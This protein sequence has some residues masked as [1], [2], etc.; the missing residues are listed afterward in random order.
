MHRIDTP[1]AQ[2]DK[3]GQ[4]KNGF[5]NGDPS[6]GIRATYLNSDMWD[7]VQEEICTV[8]EKSGIILE[9][10]QH[11]QLYEAIVG[12][13]ADSIPDALLKKNNL[14]DVLDK[15]IAR[16]NLALGTAATSNVQK[17]ATDGT[18]NALMANGAWGIGANGIGMT[19]S[20]ILS[21]TSI[22]NAFF[23]QYGGADNHF[24]SYGAGVHISY[25]TGGGNTLRLTA[26]L[27]VDASGNLSVEWLE[28][29]RNDGAVK[30]KRLQKLYGP[31]NKPTSDTVN[32]ITRDECHIA[33]FVSGNKTNPYM[34]HTASN[35]VIVLLTK[36]EASEKYQPKGSYTPAGE[37]YTKA[38]SDARYLQGVQLGA[39]VSMEYYLEVKSVPAGCV[40]TAMGAAGGNNVGTLKYKP[41]QRNINGTWV[42]ISG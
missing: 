8:I 37:A 10:E 33:G 3:F 13:I 30:A 5:T 16:K 4:G 36:L 15:A 34:R 6:T 20:D 21:P 14:S 31:L 9:K 2:V 24:G 39:A 38:E 19:D 40:I 17:S 26:N 7:A 28:V 42:T 11:D 22:G 18:V 35:E 32:A 27:F 41:I 25:G 23:V 12:L 29:N 1:T